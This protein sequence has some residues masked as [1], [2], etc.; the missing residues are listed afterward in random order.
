[1]SC[2]DIEKWF[3]IFKTADGKIKIKQLRLSDPSPFPPLV[4]RELAKD[5]YVLFNKTY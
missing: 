4:M 5:F 2:T 1:M 3:I